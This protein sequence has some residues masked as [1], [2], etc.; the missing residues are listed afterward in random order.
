MKTI[1]QLE[2]ELAAALADEEAVSLEPTTI[3]VLAR[4]LLELLRL[5]RGK[6]ESK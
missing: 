5:L 1:A 3:I 4:T 2:E 6:E